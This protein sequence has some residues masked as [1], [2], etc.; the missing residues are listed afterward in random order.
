MLIANQCQSTINEKRYSLR[1]RHFPTHEQVEAWYCG[2]HLV[3]R[4]I[5]LWWRNGDCEHLLQF[6]RAFFPERTFCDR[7]GWLREK[8]RQVV[9]ELLRQPAF[10]L[11]GEASHTS[12]MPKG[13]KVHLQQTTFAVQRNRYVLNLLLKIVFSVLF[14]TWKLS[15]FG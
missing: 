15:L 5:A 2:K 13:R 4:I 3:V 1:K 6:W 8:W 9:K 7:L 12:Q 10:H 11:V 14:I